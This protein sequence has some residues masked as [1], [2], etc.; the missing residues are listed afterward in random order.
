MGPEH[1]TV[2]SK[3]IKQTTKRPGRRIRPPRREFTPWIVLAIALL[4]TA[5]ATFLDYT[6]T[7]AK[8]ALRFE[9][10]VVVT[11]SDIQDRLDAYTT[12]L[13]STAG[14]I[15]V[16]PE[17]NPD[18]FSAYISDLRVQKM[19]PGIRGIG[20][21]KRILPKDL[22]SVIRSMRA[23]SGAP[24]RIFPDSSTTETHAVL[25]VEPRDERNQE[26]I[27]YNMYTDPDRKA[28]MDRAAANGDAAATSKVGLRLEPQADSTD[29]DGF[30]IFYPVYSTGRPPSTA[31]QRKA[32]L[33]GFVFAPFRAEDVFA[34]IFRDT[35]EPI[36]DIRIYDGPQISEAALL[37]DSRSLRPHVPA[38]YHPGYRAVQRLENAGRTWTVEYATRPEFEV[39]S[40]ENLIPFILLG[41]VS[42]SLIL[43]IITRSLAASRA[44]AEAA[45]LDLLDSQAHLVQNREEIESLNRRLQRAMTE[46]H[47][48]VKNNLQIITAM[49]DMRLMGAP[50]NIPATELSRLGMHIKSLAAVHELLTQETKED[51]EAT[52]V[53]ARAMLEKLLGLLRLSSERHIIRID[54][55]DAR[56]TG[57]QG[58]SLA[59]IVNEL[60]SNGMKHGNREVSVTFRTEM[61]VQ[62]DAG[63]RMTGVLEVCDDGPGF[64]PG[65]DPGTASNTGLEL[66]ESLSRWD[67]GG[68]PSYGT[69]D[70]GGARAIVRF[71]LHHAD[72]PKKQP[73]DEIRT[74]LVK[75]VDNGQTAR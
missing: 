13:R 57:K 52:F 51:G 64:P 1:Q 33:I 5:G 66:V 63:L 6:A 65:F 60:V 34:D 73:D 40:G 3:P 16:H 62:K 21:S 19:Y 36:L 32:S 7:R 26:L 42:I 50:E 8:D 47:H 4:L 14:L 46:T 55:S 35:S 45:A 49:L 24:F 18:Q 54:L 37:Q 39:S 58:T 61:G 41:G 68:E 9:Y 12:I 56:L 72:T 17:I 75:R 38:S 25:Y 71:P 53:S 59:L 30:L 43:F 67:L 10:S 70:S 27:G 48:R 69:S 28:A 74:E 20:F 31:A 2:D 22:Q 23:A 15:A 44:R 29:N 11:R